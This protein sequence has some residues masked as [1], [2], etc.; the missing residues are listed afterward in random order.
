[1]TITKKLSVKT[2]INAIGHSSLV[3]KAQSQF[4]PLF[5]FVHEKQ[6]AVP[7]LI[8]IKGQG[9]RVVHTTLETNG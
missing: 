9:Y 5:L 3:S 6:T 4:Y 2:V 8:G 1:M 7:I